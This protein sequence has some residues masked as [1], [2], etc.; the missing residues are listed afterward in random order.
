MWRTFFS[1]AFSVPSSFC[2]F[3]AWRFSDFAV[4]CGATRWVRRHDWAQDL[5]GAYLELKEGLWRLSE[6]RGSDSSDNA[7]SQGCSWWR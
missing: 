4:N 1:F 3:F 2:A 6:T 7:H 5:C